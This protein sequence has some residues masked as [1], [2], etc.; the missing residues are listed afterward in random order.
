M[1]ELEMALNFKNKGR[2]QRNSGVGLGW[3][4]VLDFQSG[5]VYVPDDPNKK[6][7]PVFFYSPEALS[8]SHRGVRPS[9]V[10]PTPSSSSSSSLM[11]HDVSSFL[12]CF[13]AATSGSKFASSSLPTM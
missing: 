11:A 4:G 12:D 9:S 1:S 5:A 10:S 3:S 13:S 7:T 8:N 6:K 2:F